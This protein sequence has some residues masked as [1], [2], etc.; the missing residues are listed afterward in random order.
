V[1]EANEKEDNPKEA[2][3]NYMYAA[4]NYFKWF[5]MGANVL[6]LTTEL[7]D[8]VIKLGDEDAKGE[9]II[10]KTAIYKIARNDFEGP[11]ESRISARIEPLMEALNGN[12]KDFSTNNEIELMIKELSEELLSR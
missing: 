1:G 6:Y 9:A 2:A 4:A 5:Q 11:I 7:I 8:K 3:R 10:I 12:R